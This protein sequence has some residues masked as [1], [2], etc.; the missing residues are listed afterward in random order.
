[1]A[2]T[3]ERERFRILL[4]QNRALL[5]QVRRRAQELEQ[6]FAAQKDAVRTGRKGK[7][8]QALP[9]E[10]NFDPLERL[11]G[12]GDLGP[13]AKPADA[14]GKDGERVLI[15]VEDDAD[16]RH[17]LCRALVAAGN[18]ARVCWTQSARGALDSMAEERALGARICIVADVK[19]P[20]M[21]GFQLLEL[22]KSQGARSGLQFVFLTGYCDPATKERAQ[23]QGVDAFFVKPTGAEELIEIARAIGRLS[24]AA[25]PSNE[26]AQ[27][28]V[29][30]PR[31]SP[32]NAQ[33]Q[34]R[35]LRSL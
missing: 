23:A 15:I 34:P 14:E 1:M 33:A 11:V 21:D 20:G 10:G 8:P 27:A 6:L 22:V 30:E 9:G 5:E 29:S 35:P 18:T 3:D 4:H 12:Q 28:T 32:V 7:R 31:C 19:L 16:D 13:A 2:E 26:G 17:L 24:L 25:P